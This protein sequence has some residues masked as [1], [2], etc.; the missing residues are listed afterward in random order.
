MV[1]QA[2]EILKDLL[3]ALK[4]LGY[5]LLL[6]IYA[7]YVKAKKWLF[8]LLGMTLML[9]CMPVHRPF[10]IHGVMAM[11]VECDTH[12]ICEKF[13]FDSC[14][15]GTYHIFGQGEHRLVFACTIPDD[16]QSHVVPLPDR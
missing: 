4:V 2:I 13:A 11:E 15:Y 8:A 16:N 10:P 14:W 9:G 3:Q 1:D 6:A 7:L 12:Q 5:S